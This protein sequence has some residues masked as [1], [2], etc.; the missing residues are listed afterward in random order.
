MRV[1]HKLTLTLIVGILLV[2]AGSAWVRVRREVELFQRDVA[3][4]SKVLGRALAHAVEKTWRTDGERVAVQL[5]EHATERESHLDI[6]WVWLDARP[7]AEM[8]PTASPADLAPLDRGEPVA[9]RLGPGQGAAYTY[10]PVDVPGDRRGAIEIA[11]AL[12]DEQSYLRRSILNVLVATLIL[13]LLCAAL[14]WV[15]GDALIG[16]PVKMLVE[17]AR[18]VGQGDLGQRLVPASR[19]EMGELADE[20]NRMCDGLQYARDRVAAETGARISAIE[21]LRHADRLKTVGTL[22]SGVA[23]ELGTPINVIEGYAQLIREERDATERAREGADVIVKQCR[24]MAQIIRSLLDFARRGRVDHACA[25]LRD[26]ARDTVRMLEPL[27][28]KCNVELALAPGEGAALARIASG[29]MQQVLMNIVIN[30]VHAMPQG[31]T[32]SVAL[33]RARMTP[34]SGDGDGDYL[35]VAVSDTGTGMDEETRKRIFEPFFTTKDVGEG[36]GLGLAVAY[37]I[38]QDHGGWIDVDS[39]V[40]QGS[41]FSVYLPVGPEGAAT[42]EQTS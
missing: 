34:P 31:G 32:V 40:G 6:R 17:Q 11:D 24:R 8:A 3:R 35:C 19:D 22:A 5:I 33:H 26:V 14:A 29:Q 23:H 18:R 42:E 30:A 1:S 12:E 41:R 25:D 36:T 37:G 13:V 15:L 21:Q 7:G 28:R 38:I 9:I 16:R 27:A 39:S 20:M 2:H 10:V 4:D